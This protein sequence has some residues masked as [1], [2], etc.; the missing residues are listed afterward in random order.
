MIRWSRPLPLA[1]VVLALLA[2]AAPADAR[3]CRAEVLLPTD[4]RIVPPAADVPPAIARF[5]GAWLGTWAFGKNRD[6]LCGALVVEEVF[7]SGHARVIYSHGT[8]EPHR[9]RQPGFYRATGKITDDVLRFTLPSP[10]R[11]SIVYTFADGKLSGVFAGRGEH[12]VTRVA[13]VGQV[14][15]PAT[16]AAVGA[17]PSSGRDL[18]TARDLLAGRLT[19]DHPVHND[20]FMPL[21]PS[22]PARHALK[23]TFTVPATTMASAHR[24]CRALD[25]PTP[26]F[27]VDV[28]THGEHLVPV[29]RGIVAGTLIVSPGRVWSEPGDQGLSRASFPF[30]LVNQRDNA[31]HN[32]LA[33]FVFD[34]TTVSALR[35]QVVQET[36]EWAKHDYWGQL[37]I[38]YTPRAIPDETAVRARFDEERRRHVPIRPLSAAPAAGRAPAVEGLDGD[39]PVA[40]VSAS[41]LVVDGVLYVRGCNTRYGPYPYCR[42]MRHGVF[43]VTKSLGAAIA[44]LRLAGKYG[45]AVFDA[46]IK[47]FLTVTASHDGWDD[48]TFADALGMAT[49]IGELSPHRQPNDVSA[50]ENK[51]RLLAWV[52]KPTAK[53]KLDAAFAFPKYPWRRGEV[54]RYN[55]THTFVLTAAMDAYL[56][57]KEGPGAHLWD[58]VTR[59]VFE[60]I[61]VFHAPK[62]HT[63]EPDGSRGIPLMGYGLY[64]TIDDIAKLVTLL[65]NGGRHDGRQILSAS[66]LAEA[67]YRTPTPGGLPIGRRNR[68]GESHYHLSFWSV[69]YRTTTGCFMHIPFMSGY[70]GN[71]VALLPNGVSAFRFADAMILEIE[72]LI[73][74]GEAIRPLCDPA[75]AT[76]PAVRTPMTASEIRKEVLG[77]TLAA[78]AWRMTVDA[79]GLAFFESKSDLDVGRF[80]VADDGTTCVRWNVLERARSRCFRLYRDGDRFELHAVDR[81]TLIKLERRR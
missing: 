65:Q 37:P 2:V 9:I 70:G 25:V 10:P 42:D 34:D 57:R 72:P 81:F 73:L 78:E 33:T 39:V 17:A 18:L 53:E 16:V 51:P 64:P 80:H 44:L 1:L 29:A 4:V 43:S 26:A 62:M 24:G 27:S 63:I 71:L 23:G 3:D 58:M 5:S 31:T 75:T 41:G 76:S 47:D 8:W 22:A 20:Y 48:V 6:T 49:G 21:G 77:A 55:S 59:E 19:P 35:F 28:L 32:G 36:A 56:K 60:P 45:D 11:A 54:V 50:D 13:D 38:T 67:L 74:A 7:A 40:D 12:A 68:F 66:R 15:C 14:G 69:P 79:T 52:V 46:K 61:G 30:V